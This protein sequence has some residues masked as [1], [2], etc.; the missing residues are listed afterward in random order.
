M[1]S[2]NVNDFNRNYELGYIYERVHSWE[3]LSLAQCLTIS[4]QA[5]L[6]YSYHN[7][8]LNRGLMV[9]GFY[10]GNLSFECLP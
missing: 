8:S 4:S 1:S 9:T 6:T 3:F 10:P 2:P 5:F 7:K